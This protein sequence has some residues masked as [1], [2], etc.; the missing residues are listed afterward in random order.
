MVYRQ[1]VMFLRLYYGKDAF[2]IDI[3]HNKVTIDTC[4]MGIIDETDL[5]LIVCFI[6]GC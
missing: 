1:L 6:N 3:I 4:D 2:W 5:V